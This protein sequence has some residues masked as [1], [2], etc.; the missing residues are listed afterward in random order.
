MT[1]VM[2]LTMLLRA[3]FHQTRTTQ[4]VVPLSDALLNQVLEA[5]IKGPKSS[6]RIA[7]TKYVNNMQEFSSEH[8][9]REIRDLIRGN[10]FDFKV[11]I[12]TPQTLDDTVDGT[13]RILGS[14]SS[15]YV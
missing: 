7:I 4:G 2:D 11:G 8:A 5:Y 15:G 14:M 12:P 6:I 1:Y 13:R 10:R 9:A 3:T